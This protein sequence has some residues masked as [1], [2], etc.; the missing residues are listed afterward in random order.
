MP[1]GINNRYRQRI[2]APLG[3]GVFNM[4]LAIEHLETPCIAPR[5]Y[6]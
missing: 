2:R 5:F 1:Q 3:M 6:R 4:E